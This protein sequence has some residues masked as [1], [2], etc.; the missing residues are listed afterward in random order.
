MNEL[1][2]AFLDA[3]LVDNPV[4]MTAVGALLAV[5]APRS[6]KTSYVP[7]VRFGFT[8]FLSGLI[9]G[10]LSLSVPGPVAPAVFI[11]VALAATGSLVALGEL[12]DEWMG[13]PQAILAVAPVVGV[14]LL[15][16]RHG[17][18]SLILGASAG[19]AI[20]FAAMFV[21]IGAIRE[22]SRMSETTDTFKTNP[23]VL[24]SLAMFA[25]VMTGFVFS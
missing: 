21:L 8:L 4:V 2:R 19:S 24:Y 20:G 11:V 12:R 5:V 7:A 10:G 22:S 3:M 23:V 17:D 15:V 9:G 14:Q 25:L 13:L 16:A 6:A 1:S 18:L